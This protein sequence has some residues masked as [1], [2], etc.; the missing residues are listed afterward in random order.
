MP[1]GW[2]AA[3]TA[4][5]GVLS[6][7]A[8]KSAAKTQAGAASG[9]GDATMAMFNTQQQNLQPWM[10][11]GRSSLNAL[12]ELMGTSPEQTEG[13]VDGL[14]KEQFAQKYW[15]SPYSSADP[16]TKASID[17]SWQLNSP[18]ISAGTGV[19]GMAPGSLMKMFGPSDFGANKDPSYDWRLSQGLDAVM[20]RASVGGG[21]AGSG[22]S[23]PIA[24]NTLKAINDYAQGSAS[25][26]YSAAFDRWNTMMNTIFGRLSGTSGT[27]ANAAGGIAGLGMGAVGAAGAFNT[28]AAAAL[29][30]GQVGSTNAL[31]GAGSGIANNYLLAKMFQNN[32]GGGG[33]GGSGGGSNVQWIEQ[34][35]GTQ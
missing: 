30:A 19:G 22:G 32:N 31:T 28:D 14:T 8:S 21:V 26:E 34:P 29:A 27:G 5:S 16:L 35:Q 17:Q 9:A 20:N 15:G 4:L 3:A 12:Q 25:T 2:V 10:A 1:M 6:S 33:A 7:E 23:S 13:L 24:G 18:K 11:A